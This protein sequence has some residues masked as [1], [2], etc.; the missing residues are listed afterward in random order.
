L[1]KG[2]LEFTRGFQPLPHPLPWWTPEKSIKLIC[3][4]S[5]AMQSIL[6][7]LV[8]EEKSSFKIGITDDLEARHARLSSV[9]GAF[10]LASSHT[11]AGTRQDISGLEKTLHYLLEKWRV[12]PSVK[13]EGHTEWFSI[14]CFDKALELIYSAALIRGTYSENLIAKGIVLPRQEKSPNKRIHDDSDYVIDLTG[15]KR[16]WPYYEKA[17]VDF[18]DRP[19]SQDEWVWTIKSTDCPTSPFDLLSFQIKG[20]SVALAIANMYLENTP[21]INDIVLSKNSLSYMGNYDGFR[22]A[23]EFLSEMIPRLATIKQVARDSDTSLASLRANQG[24]RADAVSALRGL[25]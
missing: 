20:R 3:L 24:S 21:W 4:F 16:D 23:Y 18:R 8:N 14:A 9:W 10:D 5:I 11:V 7:L 25:V 19:N 1:K 2:T 12:R 22:E 17:T 13:S 15:I 6:Y